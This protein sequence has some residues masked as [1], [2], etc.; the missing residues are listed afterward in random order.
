MLASRYEGVDPSLLKD[1]QTEAAQWGADRFAEEFERRDAEE[2]RLRDA[3]AGIFFRYP[4]V[5]YPGDEP[6]PDMLWGPVDQSVHHRVVE[7]TAPEA[8][9]IRKPKAIR[10]AYVPRPPR[11]DAKIRG[12]RG[13]RARREE[14][15]AQTGPR[16]PSDAELAGVSAA[17]RRLYGFDD[18]RAEARGHQKN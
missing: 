10:H 13:R 16:V 1:A 8:V 2:R 14:R 5:I 11:S 3:E 18:D 17:G 6:K 4:G 9:E 7:T 12:R 15:A